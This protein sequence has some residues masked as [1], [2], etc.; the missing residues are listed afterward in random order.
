MIRPSLKRHIP[1]R[2]VRAYWNDGRI[3]CSLTERMFK[4]KRLTED[5]L[6]FLPFSLV[7]HYA[8]GL[9]LKNDT[10]PCRDHLFQ[11][12][13]RRTTILLPRA[14]VKHPPSSFGRVLSA[15]RATA[16]PPQRINTSPNSPSSTPHFCT[17]PSRFLP[18]SLLL[19]GSERAIAA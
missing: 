16:P 4:H 2:K 12:F 3:H 6:L 9:S 5:H 18:T 15:I 13:E 8:P 14:F 11:Y 17:T 7:M 1:K 10:I 19:E